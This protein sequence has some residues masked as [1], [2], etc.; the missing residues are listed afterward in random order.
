MR[1]GTRTTVGRIS[2]VITSFNQKLYLQEAIESVLNQTLE[3]YEIII[4]DDASTDG[5][6]EVI[7]CYEQ[8]YPGLVKVVL[9]RKN[10]GISG[11][12]SSG[13]ERA[14]GDLVS[15]LDGDDRFKPRKLELELKTFLRDP[16]V[17]WVYSQV[18]VVNENGKKL[19]LRYDEPP[20]G[21]IFNDVV[22][23]LGRAPRNQLVNMQALSRIG[24]WK[25][26]MCLYE[27][28]E[29]CLRLAKSYKTAYCPQPL[30]EYRI[31]PLGIHNVAKKA[32]IDNLGKLFRHFQEMISDYPIEQR[33]ELEKLLL[34]RISV[35]SGQEVDFRRVKFAEPWRKF[36]ARFLHKSRF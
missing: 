10:I 13:I 9:Q 8:R 36:F 22:K 5:S 2:V 1:I 4:C 15:W 11:N 18:E 12:R 34:H 23:M 26:D 16:G 6:R 20:E 33:S 29:L 14:E 28:F 31:H 35:V 3:P 25:E 32:H 24:F 7:E 27:D 17:R 19:R 21:Y 30:V